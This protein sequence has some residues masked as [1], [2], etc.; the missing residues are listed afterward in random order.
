MNYKAKNKIVEAIC[1]DTPLFVKGTGVRV[2]V[3]Y[4]G[5]DLDEFRVS[6]GRKQSKAKDVRLFCNVEFV[7]SPT[8]KALKLFQRYHIKRNSVS[9]KMELDGVI[10]IENLS[11]TPYDSKAAKVL[12]E[13]KNK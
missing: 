10:D 12:Y 13:K 2:K 11:T 1:K 4:F 9:D 8:P 5:T 3:D 7:G 6:L